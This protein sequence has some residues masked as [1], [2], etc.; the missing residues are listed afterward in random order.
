MAAGGE[1]AAAAAADLNG[2]GYEEAGA[3]LHQCDVTSEARERALLA[4]LLHR[5]DGVELNV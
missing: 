3:P 5:R 2:E 1:A 4:F